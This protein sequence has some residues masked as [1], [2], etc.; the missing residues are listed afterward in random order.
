MK[1]RNRIQIVIAVVLSMILLLCSCSPMLAGPETESGT[2]SGNQEDSHETDHV[3]NNWPF[4]YF[5]GHLY[6]FSEGVLK[7]CNVLTDEV[8]CA[9][10]DPLCKHDSSDCPAFSNYIPDSRAVSLQGG[11]LYY[12]RRF[13]GGRWEFGYWDFFSASFSVLDKGVADGWMKIGV[14]VYTDVFRYWHEQIQENGEQ[15]Y[16]VNRMDLQNGAVE[17]VKKTASTEKYGFYSTERCVAAVGDRIITADAHHLYSCNENLEDRI[18]LLD[19]ETE[20]LSIQGGEDCIYFYSVDPS[21]ERTVTK[22]PLDGSSPEVVVGGAGVR[23]KQSEM[24]DYI[25]YLKSE[26]F[27]HEFSYYQK[28]GKVY[29]EPLIYSQI[30]RCRPDGSKDELLV[31]LMTDTRF[32]RMH[33]MFAVGDYVFALAR[34]F[35]SPDENGV[36]TQYL[37]GKEFRTI[38]AGDMVTLVKIDVRTGELVY[39]G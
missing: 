8:S 1:N 38:Q 12:T 19:I 2:S 28:N 27:D 22:L 18:L 17:T 24:T 21:V 13:L 16:L 26:S 15:F 29:T 6:Y 14:D 35:V 32:I 31:N 33:G 11:K 30:R 5:R 7:K 34:I 39:I 20:N 25:Y 10:M 4:L 9:C 37:T 3:I 23:T 36:F